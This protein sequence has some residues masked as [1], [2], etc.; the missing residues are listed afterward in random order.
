MPNEM[1]TQQKIIEAWLDRRW[2]VI[3]TRKF[4]NR[5]A[6]PYYTVQVFC[7]GVEVGKTSPM[8]GEVSSMIWPTFFQMLQKHVEFGSWLATFGISQWDLELCKRSNYPKFLWLPFE[9]KREKDL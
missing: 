2:F 8:R 6:G 5:N 7:N 3:V 4:Y 1:L 9:V